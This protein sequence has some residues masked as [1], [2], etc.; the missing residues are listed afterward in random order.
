MI[1]G[2]FQRIHRAERRFANSFGR[3]IS[4]PSGRRAAWMHF[5][6]FDHA[7]LRFLW[8]NEEEIAPGVWRSNQP[9]PG[10]LARLRDRGIRTVINLRGPLERSHYLFEREACETLGLALID[11][12]LKAR[13]LVP[14][15]N[16]LALFDAFDRARKPLILHCKSGSDRAGLASALWLLDK[17]GATLEAALD[18]MSFRFLHLKNSNTGVLDAVLDAYAAHVAQ[19]GET[20]VRRWI[21]E[22]YDPEEIART[23]RAAL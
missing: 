7:F 3:D 17:E 19:H 8:T 16:M 23:F 1:Q 12:D 9:T 21:A 10:R 14:R 6:F 13:R 22:T 2:L 5:L 20:P 11:V 18:M 15:E 4:T